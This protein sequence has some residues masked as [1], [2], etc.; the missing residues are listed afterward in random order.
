MAGARAER[1][2]IDALLRAEARELSQA[3]SRASTRARMQAVQVARATRANGGGARL[4]AAWIKPPPAHVMRAVGRI[5]EG[6]IGRA[7][8]GGA[9]M[10][11]REAGGSRPVGNRGGV[12]FHIKMGRTGSVGPAVAHQSYI[13]RDGACVASFGNI[14]E[15]YEERCRLWRALGER[16]VQR[17]GCVGSPQ[18]QTTT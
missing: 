5:I 12:S 15:T 8:R 17:G 14:H 18:T 10:A 13:E 11:A 7:I 9:R 3:M 2:R 6:G 1:A 4:K 16:T